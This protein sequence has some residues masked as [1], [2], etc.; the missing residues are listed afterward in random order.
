MFAYGKKKPPRT[1]H[2]A[3]IFFKEEDFLQ[4]RTTE[5]L[6]VGLIVTNRFLSL[7]S[8]CTNFANATLFLSCHQPKLFDATTEVSLREAKLVLSLKLRP[9]YTYKIS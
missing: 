1:T 6:A 8:S 9:L 2:D 4:H 7:V 3:L 5:V